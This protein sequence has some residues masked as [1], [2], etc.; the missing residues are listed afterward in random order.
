MSVNH[1]TALPPGLRAESPLCTLI[2]CPSP[3]PTPH[4]SSHSFSQ[5]TVTAFLTAA[6]QCPVPGEQ[7][8]HTALGLLRT[9]DVTTCCPVVSKGLCV[10]EKPLGFRTLRCYFFLL[11]LI[12]T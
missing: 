4:L 8:S 10:P 7:T 12:F 5:E 11:F 1:H 2:L 3:T 6:S 9:H